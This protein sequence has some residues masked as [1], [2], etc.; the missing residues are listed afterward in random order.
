M[1]LSSLF[2]D[3]SDL[4]GNLRYSSTS[5]AC[6]FVRRLYII[7]IFL[8]KYLY[9]PYHPHILRSHFLISFRSLL[10]YQL[11]KEGFSD[12]LDRLAIPTV[13]KQLQLPVFYFTAPLNSDRLDNIGFLSSLPTRIPSFSKADTLP[14][15]FITVPLGI[16]L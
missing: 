9:L 1:K 3:K 6:S 5:H 2:E 11:I 13:L 16:E 15:L 7:P 8:L 10:K 4:S 12:H 14:A